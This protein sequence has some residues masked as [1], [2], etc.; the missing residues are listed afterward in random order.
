VIAIWILDQE[1]LALGDLVAATPV[2]R[3]DRL[4]GLFIDELLAQ[5]IGGGLIDL[6][7]CDALGTRARRMQRN[8]TETRAGLRYPFQ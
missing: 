2:F 5:A 3:G 4:E 7:E 1:V 8:R 6:P